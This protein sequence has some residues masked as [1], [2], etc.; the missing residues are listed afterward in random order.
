MSMCMSEG[1]T[2]MHMHMSI[3]CACSDKTFLPIHV[4]LG[5]SCTPTPTHPH[6]HTQ[7]AC[8]ESMGFDLVSIGIML[9]MWFL[10]LVLQSFF[11]HPYTK[12]YCLSDCV[13]PF[14]GR[15]KRT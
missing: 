1:Y 12:V 14:H 3:A 7:T 9:A 4:Y 11:Y 13:R 10:F 15:R 8:K 6:I 2:Y 5:Q